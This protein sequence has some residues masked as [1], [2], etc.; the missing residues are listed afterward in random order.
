MA[1]RQAKSLRLVECTFTSQFYRLVVCFPSSVLAP[2]R[3]ESQLRVQYFLCF[4]VFL[5]T[6]GSD[7]LRC[8][9]R[10]Y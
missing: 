4:R 9:H 5:A 1:K 8:P 6:I 7:S 2:A 3:E 10:I